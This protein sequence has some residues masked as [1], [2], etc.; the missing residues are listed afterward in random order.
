MLRVT[1]PCPAYDAEFEKAKN[2]TEKKMLIKYD[3]FFKYVSNHTGLEIK[4]LSDVEN[5]FNSLTIQV[6]VFYNNNNY[7]LLPPILI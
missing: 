1:V 6:I 4:H 2:E 5:I 7:L 3:N